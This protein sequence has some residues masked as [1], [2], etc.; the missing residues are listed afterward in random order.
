MTNQADQSEARV[1]GYHEEIRALREKIRAEQAGLPLEPVE[2]YTLGTIEGSQQLSEFFG[3]KDTLLLVHNMG[4]QCAY[5]TL[6]AD[7]LNGV[8]DHVQSRTAVLVTSPDAPD[9]QTAFSATRGW[10][11]AMASTVGTT[12]IEDLGFGTNTSPHPGVTALRK[13]G[14]AIVRLASSPFGPGDDFCQVYHLWNLLPEGWDS[15]I[16]QFTYPA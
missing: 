6:W 3:E 11:F 15:W 5:C 14:Q 1:A 13:D 7:G 4:S 2:N 10:R 8:L 16:P 9:V 12:L